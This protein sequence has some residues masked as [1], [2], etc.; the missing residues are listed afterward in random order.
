VTRQP[1]NYLTVDRRGRNGWRLKRTSG[2]VD[3]NTTSSSMDLGQPPT[4]SRTK[5]QGHSLV[6]HPSQLP[7]GWYET[8]SGPTRYWNG[9][10]WVTPASPPTGQLTAAPTTTAVLAHLAMF[11]SIIATLVIYLLADRTN[12]FTR[13]HVTEALNFQ[14]TA[15]IVFAGIFIAAL[16]TL[17][18]AMVLLLPAVVVT[19]AWPIKAAVAASR[20]QQ[21]RYPICLRL[22]GLQGLASGGGS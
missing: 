2:V 14:I 7:P 4:T 9:S 18:L 3:D 21:W 5:E 19:V 6:A 17:G 22:V 13:A 10:A 1:G 12:R 8:P 16:P 15:L 20:H 11:F